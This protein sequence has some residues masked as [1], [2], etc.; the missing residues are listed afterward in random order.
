MIDSSCNISIE[1]VHDIQALQFEWERLLAHSEASFFLSWHWIGSWIALQ[2]ENIPLKQL[3]VRQEGKVVALAVFS[4]GKIRRHGMFTS[5]VM[6]LHE[7]TSPGFN[8]VIEYNG[9]LVDR[10]SDAKVIQQEI[11]RF[12]ATEVPGWDELQ[13]SGITADCPLIEPLFLQSMGLQTH[14]EC[15]SEAKCVNLDKIRNNNGDY[16]STLSK[17]TRYKLRKYIKEYECLGLI[18]VEAAES[19]D[20]AF[21]YFDE[22]KTYHQSYWNR[23]GQTGSFANDNWEHF[24]RNVI[25]C[26]FSEGGVQ[27][28]KI[29]AGETIIGYLYNLVWKGHVYMIQSGYRYDDH[30]HPGYVSLYYAIDYNLKKE[31]RVFD[32]LAGKNQYKES[33]SNDSIK[34]QWVMLQRKKIKFW[35]E[36]LLRLGKR[37]VLGQSSDVSF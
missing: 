3:T 19:L 22:L 24:Q 31:Y 25:K 17:K 8:M 6:A 11:I 33:L 5:A 36:D 32:F 9:I 35:I 14:I 18:K 12:L 7:Y 26:A 27:L 23:K 10:Q 1:D 21:Q 20:E 13:L 29:S 28:L 15:E 30:Y 4:S 34:L 16:F 37:K 2:P